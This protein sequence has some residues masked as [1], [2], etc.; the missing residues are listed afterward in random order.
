MKPALKK[1]SEIFIN[2]WNAPVFRYRLPLLIYI[3]ISLT[4]VSGI[5]YTKNVSDKGHALHIK[6]DETHHFINELEAIRDGMTND[7]M[8]YA[9][10]GDRRH[11]EN[12]MN[13]LKDMK[14]SV[15]SLKEIRIAEEEI[16]KLMASSEEVSNSD[17][18]AMRMIEKGRGNMAHHIL[19]GEQYNQQRAVF[20]NRLNELQRLIHKRLSA[21]TNEAKKKIETAFG[22]LILIAFVVPVLFAFELYSR[23]K[24]DDVLKS[25]RKFSDVMLDSIG[26]GL[27]VVDRDYRIV[28]ANK[29]YLEQCRISAGDVVKRH[30]FEVSHHIDRPCYLAGEDCAVKHTFETGTS[31]TIIHTHYDKD[32]NPVYVETRAYPIRNEDG[33]VTSAVEIVRDVTR[34]KKLEDQL[35]H[36][37]KMESIGTLAGG[38]A[39]DFN[40]ILTVIMGFSSL[41]QMNMEKDD[42]DMPFLNEITSAGERAADLTRGLLAFSRKQVI[43]P[44]QVNLNGI[45]DTIRKMLTRIIGE[46]IQLK[47]ILTDKNP[48]VMSDAGQIEQVLMN[49]AANARD[50]MPNGGMLTIETSVTEAGEEFS[51]LLDENRQVRHAIITVSDTGTGIDAKVR[52]R[53]FEPYFTTKEIGKGTGLGL[54]IVYGIIKQHKGDIQCY[55][56]PDKGTTFKIFLPLIE[57]D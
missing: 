16:N 24:A 31:H 12:Y 35:F 27:I 54:S 37:Q 1:I 28:T 53:I 25:T 32:N 49:L 13:K 48:T 46:D 6:H 43:T 50:A 41:M 55:S 40:N 19:H 38:I 51:G 39:H 36:A 8:R 17:F 26:E 30:C 23:K 3:S 20:I 14:D 56:K 29:A 2:F 47:T 44:K 10:H 42:P 5:Y 45:I 18:K 15:E 21:E 33:S 22:I 4:L 34:E 11:L 52:E 9:M 57:K 7:A